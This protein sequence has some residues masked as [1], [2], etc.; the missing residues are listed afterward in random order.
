[1][2]RSQASYLAEAQTLSHTG[3]FGWD[4]STGKIF[5][6]EETFRI[7]GYEPTIAIEILKPTGTRIFRLTVTD[8]LGDPPAV[9]VSPDV[10][11]LGGL[12]VS[13]IGPRSPLYGQ[14]RGVVVTV[15]EADGPAHA[16][17]IRTNDIIQSVNELRITEAGQISE[18][19]QYAV[20]VERARITRAGTPYIVEFSGR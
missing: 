16:S 19:A 12:T 7:F 13:S 14:M 18:L 20:P 5:W 1:L 4:L 15:V 8:Q 3:S 11:G 10:L 17:G 2:R 9:T 6:S